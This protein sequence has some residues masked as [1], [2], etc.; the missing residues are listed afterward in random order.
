M[1][2]QCA[3]IH[4]LSFHSIRNLSLCF[5]LLIWRD[6]YP[7]TH[8]QLC[9]K[10]VFRVFYLLVLSSRAINLKGLVIITCEGFIIIS[11]WFLVVRADIAAGRAPV[12]QP[13]PLEPSILHHVWITKLDNYVLSINLLTEALYDTRCKLRYLY[14]LIKWEY[15]AVKMSEK[16]DHSK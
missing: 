14:Q 11:M 12:R 9:Y 4:T 3:Q 13:Y 2:R 15:L 8:L 5:S 1:D 16:H 7:S 10:R 6:C